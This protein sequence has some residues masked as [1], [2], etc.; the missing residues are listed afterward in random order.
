M[1]AEYCIPLL[2]QAADLGM[3]TQGFSWVVTEGVTTYLVPAQFDGLIGTSPA[4]GDSE[5][6]NLY[7]VSIT[8]YFLYLPLPMAPFKTAL[9]VL[10]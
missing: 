7:T 9:K 3:F 2:E 8:L 1:L 10:V 5:D 4:T 6:W